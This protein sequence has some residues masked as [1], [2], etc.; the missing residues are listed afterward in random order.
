MAAER[1][2]VF[3]TSSMRL[4]GGVLVLIQH[5]NGLVE[6]GYRVTFVT[7]AG[8]AAPEVQEK[9]SPQV[10]IRS[11]PT[12]M[13]EALSLSGKV[14]LSWQMA[15]LVPHCDT[16]IASH[17]PAVVPALAAHHLLRRSRRAIWFHQD[18]PE[19]FEDRPIEQWLLRNAPRWFERVLTVSH[20]CQEEIERT[21][22][23]RA[24]VVPQG[25]SISGELPEP[26]A[27]PSDAKVLMY[28]GDRRPRKGWA[29]FLAAAES[30]YERHPDLRLAI[31][32]K[33]PGDLDT[34]VPHDLHVRPSWETVLELYR[35]CHVFVFASWWEGFG[36]PPLEAMACG[37][38]VVTTDSRGVRE[39][40]RHEVNCLM[41]PIQDPGALAA[42]IDRVLRD[43]DLARRLGEAGRQTA[44]EFTWTR[45]VE[46]FV[47][48]LESEGQP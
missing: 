5:A 13:E 44:L 40:A 19:M 35:S 32:S 23:V 16:V 17:T 28:L 48:A 39:Y 20:A 27:P 30:L 4:S 7:S 37:T 36:R 41:T 43:P 38:P 26:A 6:R 1:S 34:P 2:I 46:R 33:E 29:D 11:A 15:R 8:G 31:V 45:A 21:S 14:R 42:A 10:E 12:V 9:L 25:Y 47:E 18:Y 22:G 3:T 24:W